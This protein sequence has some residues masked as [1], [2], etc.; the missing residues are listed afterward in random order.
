[1]TLTT[2]ATMEFR[3]RLPQP[4]DLPSLLELEQRAF[5]TDRLSRKRFLHWFRASQATFLLTVDPADQV[6]GYALILYRRN[7]QKARLYSI[8]VSE[9]YRGHGLAQRLLI[10]AERAARQRGCSVLYLEVRPDNRAAIT[11]YQRQGYS[12]IGTRQGFY[13]DGT[14]ALRFEKSLS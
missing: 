6:A 13:E 12:L 1:M 11:L 7:S 8:A 5:V 14:D 2:A 9:P 3:L 10:A 4:A